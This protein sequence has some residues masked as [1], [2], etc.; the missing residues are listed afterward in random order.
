MITNPTLEATPPSAFMRTQSGHAHP[1]P[2]H[3]RSKVVIGHPKLGLG[4]SES[5]VMWLIEALKKDFDVTIATTG[6][7]N[8]STLND[9]YGTRIEQDE[10]SMRIAPLPWPLQNRSVAALRGAAYQRFARRIAYE[11]DVRISAYNLTDWGLPAIH[12]LADFSWNKT[13]RDRLDP[14]SPGFVYK[15]SLLRKAYMGLAST[16]DSPSGRDPLRDDLLIANSHWTAQTVKQDCKVQCAATIYPPVWSDFP[17]V[18]WDQ[19]ESSFVMIG[20]ISPEKQ[21]EKAIS[22]LS[23]VRNRGHSIKLHLCGQIEDDVY[24]RQIAGL[25]RQHSDWIIPE[26]RVTGERKAAILANCRYGIQARSAEPFGI[27]VA[28]MVKAGAIVFAPHEGGQAEILQNSDLLF[29]SES[30]AVAKIHRVLEDPSLQSEIRAH[31]HSRAVSFSTSSFISSVQELIS[32]AMR[33]SRRAG[34]IIEVPHQ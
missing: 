24:G 34:D 4:G 22:I 30:D 8:R 5:V 14:P 25:C 7:W 26:G 17:N 29:A 23:S 12:F 19:K 10:V 15:D 11:Y 32:P 3:H 13:I 16:F 18:S 28:E 33:Q 21:I 9:F 20:R 1:R 27:S 2:E 31:L 6:G